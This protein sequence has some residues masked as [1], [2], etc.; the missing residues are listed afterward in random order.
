MFEITLCSVPIGKL[1]HRFQRAHQSLLITDKVQRKNWAGRDS[2][3]FCRSFKFF[4]LFYGESRATLAMQTGQVQAAILWEFWDSSLT[5]RDQLSLGELGMMW[6][7]FNFFLT[8]FHQCFAWPNSYTVLWYKAHLPRMRNI[9]LSSLAL[10]PC[11]FWLD[12]SPLTCC[13][14][15]RQFSSH[16]LQCSLQNIS[17]SMHTTEAAEI[18]STTP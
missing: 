15:L 7:K 2:F 1:T 12:S 9:F 13:K 4:K 14:C 16:H 18:H 6:D 17:L 5:H 3:W 10:I 11:L 8:A